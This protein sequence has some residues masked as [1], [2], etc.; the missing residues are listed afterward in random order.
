M[1]HVVHGNQSTHWWEY[2]YVIIIIWLLESDV[3]PGRG[4]GEICCKVAPSSVFQIWQ[5][6][7]VRISSASGTLSTMDMDDKTSTMGIRCMV[8]RWQHVDFRWTRRNLYIY[9]KKSLGTIFSQHPFLVW[10]NSYLIIC[11]NNMAIK[12]EEDF[13]EG[14]FHIFIRL[15]CQC[16]LWPQAS[17]CSREDK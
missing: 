16:P 5:K 14:W 15:R 11:P 4:G 6:T 10:W 13:D 3:A 2:I 7:R 17:T 12:H 9:I 8:A 1:N